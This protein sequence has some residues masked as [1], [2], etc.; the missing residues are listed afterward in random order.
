VINSNLDSILD[1]LAEI[2]PREIQTDVQTD[3]NHD[4]MARPL[5]KY[6]RLI[7]S[8]YSWW[9]CIV[10]FFT[11]K[12]RA[13]DFLCPGERVARSWWRVVPRGWTNHKWVV[14]PTSAFLK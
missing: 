7:M 12:I 14:A 6:G 1:Y 2:H 10:F 8:A 3:D 9:L 4:S 13:W 5:L 11:K